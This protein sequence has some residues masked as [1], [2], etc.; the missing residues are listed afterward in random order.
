MSGKV[1]VKRVEVFSN[2]WAWPERI[3]CF[4]EGQVF[5]RSLWFGSTHTP[6]PLSRQQVTS[7]SQSSCLSPVKLGGEERRGWAWRRIIQYSLVVTVLCEQWIPS[8]WSPPFPSERSSPTG[9]RGRYAQRSSRQRTGNSSGWDIFQCCGY[10]FFTVP[11]PAPTFDKFRLQIRLLTSYD[12]SCGSVSSSS[13]GS[14]STVDNKKP[15]LDKK[16]EKNRA[17]LNGK[18]FTRKFFIGFIKFI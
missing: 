17:F 4:T 14:V 2:R 9:A 11:V 5:L 12:S 18:L 6:F 15:G 7:L 8:R 10:L 1:G 3:K 13:T 16:L